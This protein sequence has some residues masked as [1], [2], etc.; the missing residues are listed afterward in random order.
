M[1]TIIINIVL[2]LI[3][4]VPMG[5]FMFGAGKDKT[6]VKN[7]KSKAREA[8][9]NPDKIGIWHG[10]MIGLDIQKSSLCYLSS[11]KDGVLHIIDMN[12]I[13]HCE[14]NKLYH[15]ENVHNQAT[16]VLMSVSLYITKKDKSEV[17]IPVYD[18]SVHSQIGTDLMEANDWANI[19]NN[20]AHSIF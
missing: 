13:K 6:A 17:V 12:E 7:F 11:L 3:I 10:G 14:V 4:V 19:I 1:S 16:N 8:G 20:K 2:V 5:Y 18:S 9:L 15:K